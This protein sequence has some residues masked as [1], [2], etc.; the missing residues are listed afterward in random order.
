MDDP[1]GKI[2]CHHSLTD[3]HRHTDKRIDWQGQPMFGRLSYDQYGRLQVK[4]FLE[5]RCIY[6]H[7]NTC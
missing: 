1:H 7:L 5:H 6:I 3:G 2:S 4:L